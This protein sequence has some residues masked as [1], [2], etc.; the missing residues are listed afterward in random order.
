MIETIQKPDKEESVIFDK[1]KEIIFFLRFI[2]TVKR[3]FY[4]FVC[5]ERSAQGLIIYWAFK[6]SSDLCQEA[7]LLSPIQLLARFAD[8]YGLPVTVGDITSKFIFA[9]RIEVTSSDPTQLVSI[10]NPENHSFMNCLLLKVLQKDRT[11]VAD[12]ALV[13][14]IDTTRYIA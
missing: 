9:H 7:N 12:C 1:Q 6:I 4:M 2:S 3:K 14:C 13:F 8:M 11:L 5:A 10:H